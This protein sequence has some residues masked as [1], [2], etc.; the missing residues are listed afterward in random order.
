[1]GQQP[2][3]ENRPLPPCK[4]LSEW[5]IVRMKTKLLAFTLVLVMALSSAQPA[6]ASNVTLTI[7]NNTEDVIK[8]TLEGPENYSFNVDPGWTYKEVEEGSYEFKLAGCTATPNG[9]IEID[10][11]DVVLEI[12]QCPA[13]VFDAKFAVNAHLSGIT[14]NMSGP[15]EYALALNLGRN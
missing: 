6:F 12:E 9:E 15:E 3:A 1:M 2:L 10:D 4:P 13:E 7:H 14:L 8:V 11:D 5:S